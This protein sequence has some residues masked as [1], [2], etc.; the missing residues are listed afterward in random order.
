MEKLN[1]GSIKIGNI[2]SLY[3]KSMEGLKNDPIVYDTISSK[4]GLTAKEVKA[5]L[6]ILLTY[7]EDV[8]YCANCPGLDKCKKN[9]PYLKMDLEKR[10]T[11]VVPSF[12]PCKEMSKLEEKKKM[13][14]TYSFPEN[15]LDN[16]PNSIDGDLIRLDAISKLGPICSNDSKSGWV[17]IYGSTRSGKT[18]ILATFAVKFAKSHPGC[19][20][21][22][23]Q[24]LLEKFKNLSYSNKEEFDIYFD[25]IKNAPLLVI[26]DF[27][28][29]YKTE[30]TFSTYLLPLLDYRNKQ[31]L[32][33]FF[34][35][36]FSI[37]QIESLY[38]DKIGPIY[39][40]QLKDILTR[41]CGNGFDIS[42]SLNLY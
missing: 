35:S 32:R 36:S 23:C 27:G 31:G 25:K 18:Y 17:Y 7:Q 34:G 39:A 8:N 12:S 15:Y 16:D 42:T 1:L 14:F 28:N 3:K 33:T 41:N 38:K 21:V 24:S 2:D 19:A 26:D 9:N 30:Y 22:S 4:L 6:A 13:F 5:N 20:Y 29:E 11:L 40:R 37:K 10:E